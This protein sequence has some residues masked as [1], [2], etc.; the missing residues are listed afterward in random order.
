MAEGGG[1]R[2][3][4]EAVYLRHLINKSEGS[5][6]QTIF[7]LNLLFRFTD[8]A[9]RLNTIFILLKAFSCLK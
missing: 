4:N 3:L 9:G 1:E 7:I 6:F 2:G 5:K 8:N